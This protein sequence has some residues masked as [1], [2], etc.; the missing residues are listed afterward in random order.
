[1]VSEVLVI[2]IL[3]FGPKVRQNSMVGSIWWSKAAHLMAARKQREE[4]TRDKIHPSR[5]HPSNL[6]LLTRLHLLVSTT[7]Q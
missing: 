3:S 5:A 6:L 1:M 4:R 7:S 2:V